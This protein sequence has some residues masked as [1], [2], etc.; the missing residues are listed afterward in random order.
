MRVKIV[1]VEAFEALP[2]EGARDK[3]GTIGKE[4][5]PFVGHLEE[6]QECELLDVV[7]IQEAVIAEDVA[8]VPEFLNDGV[9]GHWIVCWVPV[10]LWGNLD[11]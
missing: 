7:L 11:C 5:L 1:A 9:A 10:K 2:V 4:L 8:V 6:E 3:D